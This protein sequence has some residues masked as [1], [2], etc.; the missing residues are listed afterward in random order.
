MAAKCEAVEI[1]I[2]EHQLESSGD[3]ELLGMVDEGSFEGADDK[4][5][6]YMD[7]TQEEGTSYYKDIAGRVTYRFVQMNHNDDTSV[8]PDTATSGNSYFVIGNPVEVFGAQSTNKKMVRR[9]VLPSKAVIAK[10]RDDK[11]RATHNEV[12]RRRRDKINS[13]ITKLAA[14]V[15]HAGLPDSASKGGILAKACDYITELN[16]KQK[17]FDEIE[18]ENERLVLDVMKLNKEVTDLL[19]DNTD[20]RASLLQIESSAEKS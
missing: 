15:P 12:E 19:R 13:W 6:P 18:R 9:D 4:I 7:T 5:Q 10:K 16:E 2:D 11:R 14:L 17:R 3:G 1:D 8:S 20:L